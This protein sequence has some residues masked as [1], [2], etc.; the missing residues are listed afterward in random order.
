MERRIPYHQKGKGLERGYSPPPR[1]RIRAPDLDTSDLIEANALTLIGRLSNPLGQRMWSL[2]PFL[3]NRWN[4]R[5]KAVGADLGR[6]VFQFKFDNED[7][8]LKVLDNRPYHFDQWMVIL[9]RWEPTISDDFPSLI[10]FWVELQ[11]LPKHFWQPEMLTTI[12]EEFGELMDMEISSSSAKIRVLLNG[13][14]PITKESVVEFPD[15]S[16]T[17]VYLDYKNLKSHCQHCQRLTHDL[18]SCPGLQSE[19]QHQVKALSQ[20]TSKSPQVTR[21]IARNYYSPGDNFLAPKTTSQDSDRRS[22]PHRDQ[23]PLKRRHEDSGLRHHS[24]RSYRPSQSQWSPRRSSEKATDHY[25]NSNQRESTRSPHFR[26][27][28]SNSHH[29]SNLQW[30]EKTPISRETPLEVS[31]SSRSRRPPL[32]RNVSNYD[33]ISKSPL[34]RLYSNTKRAITN[35]VSTSSPGIPSKEQVLSDLRD[36]TIQYT[37]CGDPT[38]SAA[39]KLRVIQG[40]A[41]GLMNETATNIIEAAIANAPHLLLSESGLP[42]ETQSTRLALSDDLCD[43]ASGPSTTVKRGRGRPPTHKQAGK[44]SPK[45]LGAKS[46]KRNFAQGSPKKPSVHA[47]PE[48]SGGSKPALNKPGKSKTPTSHQKASS[49]AANDSSSNKLSTSG[50]PKLALIPGIKKNGADFQNPQIPLP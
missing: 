39:R 35:E 23:N 37:S 32:E 15:G 46:Q 42:A 2:F 27:G 48:K 13:L 28:N 45:L 7:D 29:N 49:S 36:V 6:G 24:S 19:K 50:P 9:Q 10:P 40:E 5:G 47:G 26:E 11:G 18:K 21:G 25:R 31:D 1:K 12:G 3:L 14:Q 22:S 4:L 8:L 33:Q 41:R 20:T 43:L 38:E 17:I 44:P 34:Q 16:E 30:R